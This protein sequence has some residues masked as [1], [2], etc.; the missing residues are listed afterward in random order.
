MKIDELIKNIIKE[1]I[2]KLINNDGNFDISQIDINTLK[3]I[4][5]DFRLTPSLNCYDYPL[6]DNPLLCEER[7]D[8]VEPDE[9]VHLIQQKY[10]LPSQMIWKRESYH[11]IY[12]YI[13]TAVIGENDKKIEN[14]MQKLGYYL[15]SRGKIQTI[16]DM[17]FQVLQFEPN[18]EKLTD[19]T[20]E[21]KNKTDY[22]LHWT[23]E[24]NIEHILNNGL[25]PSSQNCIFSYPNRIYLIYDK[26]E[27]EINLLGKKLCY[28]NKNPKNNGIYCLLRIDISKINDDV[29]FYYDSN[30]KTGIFTEQ[31]IPSDIIQ[32]LK[33]YNFNKN[34]HKN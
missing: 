26:D 19:V 15:G 16:Q 8:I 18:S 17:Q 7:G 25:I 1:N 2:N 33:Y 6:N 22:L 28:Y 34:S 10:N 27:T 23:P 30:T 14:D 21:I 13:I 20:D 24:Y 29:K 32:I 11:Q 3:S 31:S 12:V 5:W 9:V 4:Y